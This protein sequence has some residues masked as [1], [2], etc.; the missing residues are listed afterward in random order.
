MATPPDNKIDFAIVT[1]SDEEFRAISSRLSGKKRIRISTISDAFEANFPIKSRS[2][3]AGNYR[4]VIARTRMGSRESAFAMQDIISRWSPRYIISVGL[5]GGFKVHDINIGDILLPDHIIDYETQKP[6]T[7]SRSR[8]HTF[9]RPDKRL[10]AA[11]LRVRKT[12]WFLESRLGFAPKVWIGPI[13]SGD[14]LIRSASELRDVLKRWPKLTGVEMEAG[15]IAAALQL[16]ENSPPGILVIRVVVNLLERGKSRIEPIGQTGK[17]VASFLFEILKEA[18]VLLTEEADSVPVRKEPLNLFDIG[19]ERAEK[20]ESLRNK[21]RTGPVR[22]VVKRPEAQV[23]IPPEGPEEI[24]GPFQF[25]FQIPSYDSDQEGDNDYLSIEQDVE[26]FASL[27]CARKTLPPL[28]IGL[29]GE[30]GSGKTFFMRKLRNRVGEISFDARK[31]ERLQKDIAYYKR[32]VQIEFNAWHY[33]EGNLWASLVEHILANLRIQG[34]EQDII[35]TLQKKLLLELADQKT[36]EEQAQ[37]DVDQAQETLTSLEQEI[38]DKKSEVKKVSEDLYNLK[39]TDIL[40]VVFESVDIK[41]RIGTLRENFEDLGVSD[42]SNSGKDFLSAFDELQQALRRG[43]A[44]LVPFVNSPQRRKWI[45]LF[46]LLIV[47]APVVG[48]GIGWLVRLTGNPQDQWLS[49]YATWITTI[50]TWMGVVA[51]TIRKS[52]KW[53]SDRITPIEQLKKRID[54]QVAQAQSR[55][56]GEI[57]ELEKK[58]VGLEHD[59]EAALLKRDEAKRN[60]ELTQE[61][62]EQATPARM[63]ANFI[64]DRV[65][66]NDYRKHL[67][68]LALVRTDFEKLSDFIGHENKECE[69]FETLE[70][71]AK[72]ADSRINRIVLYIDDLDRCS[73]EKVIQVL[74]AVH[75]LLAFQLFVVVVAVDA[76]WVSGA[77]YEQYGNLLKARNISKNGSGKDDELIGATALDYLEKIFQIP[78]WL[79]PM[80][81]AARKAMIDGLV[82]VNLAETGQDETPESG[83]LDPKTLA[84]LDELHPVPEEETAQAPENQEETETDTTSLLTATDLNPSALTIAPM[85][86]EFIDQLCPLLGRSPRALK[87]FVNVYRLVKSSL[88]EEWKSLFLSGANAEFRVA[89]FLLAIVT[90]APEFSQEFFGSLYQ[91]RRKKP[92][93]TKLKAVDWDRLFGAG[94]DAVLTREQAHLVRWIRTKEAK[95]IRDASLERLIWWARRTARFSFLLEPAVAEWLTTE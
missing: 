19:P 61:K 69:S 41:D 36:N 22:K 35:K 2:G 63:L 66:S 24:A 44:V 73:T 1:S 90:H 39:A 30:W 10:L 28:S 92:Q 20:P 51:G 86:Q 13:V 15:G 43:G 18:P 53:V 93:A 31:S 7:K 34:E 62:L 37:K 14:E 17:I 82:Q 64:Q 59:K 70:Q 76:R 56:N 12:Q 16:T 75:L 27:I 23:L 60:V 48:L 87:R 77:L 49:Q 94:K 50:V 21:S 83:D 45:L 80:N 74:Q 47:L 78:F 32:I 4:L 79:S 11:A 38:D 71:E 72:D 67:G 52:A 68:V 9:Y 46:M 58:R 81:L 91:F 25:P 89:M 85:E 42:L 8:P 84:G 88:P 26:A 54:D 5:A 40:N 57:A 55:L 65:Q 95:P 29:F 3:L 6:G 33:A